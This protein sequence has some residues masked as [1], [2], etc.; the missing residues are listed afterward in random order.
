MKERDAITAL[1]AGMRRSPQQTNA[2][3]A[4]D[5]EIID[6]DGARW[7]I[8]VDDYSAEDRWDAGTASADDAG[9]LG[10]NLVT[11]TLSDL[12]AVGAVPRFMLNSFVS[13]PRMDAAW[14]RALSAGM[15]RAL[16]ACGAYML[17]GDLGTGA[18]WRFTG[19]A[20]GALPAGR[21]ALSRIA[22]APSGNVLVSGDF[23]DANLAA[24][25]DLGAPRLE[26]RLAESQ[27][28]A[29]TNADA[30]GAC[31]DT[32]D[33]LVGAL[34]ALC[35]CDAGL[36]IELDCEAVPY[37]AGID[38]AARALHLPREIFLMGSAGEYELVALAPE[39]ADHQRHGLR[40]IGRFA[41]DGDPG[42]HFHR[43]GRWIAHPGLPDPR[44]AAS[45]EEYRGRL[46]ALARK[47]FDTK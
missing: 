30:G 8:T 35:L 2:P 10:W 18:E 32:S 47:L 37:A 44:E 26:I 40:R 5:A 7:A 21:A 17:G 4:S 34:E 14:L 20:L 29:E 27:W 19:V 23:G 41:H 38:A 6:L 43:G 39:P 42:L 15:D 12:L 33:G 45:L 11:A 9:T 22:R 46:I 3:F 25:S 31:I 16:D 1:I 13:T 28:L 24:A 36:R